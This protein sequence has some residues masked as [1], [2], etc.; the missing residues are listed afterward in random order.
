MAGW[1]A[2]QDAKAA[3]R[4]L[5]EF[6]L[7]HGELLRSMG[8]PGAQGALLYGPPGCGKTLLAKAAATC[9]GA[10]FVSVRG[11]ELLQMWLGESERA[12]RTL[13]EAARWVAEC[14][15]SGREQRPDLA[16]FCAALCFL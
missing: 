3:L 1:L 4:E 14:V 8:F 15:L 12:V 5:V 9:C 13:F 16:E 11:P 10:N 7:Q 6:P 2:V